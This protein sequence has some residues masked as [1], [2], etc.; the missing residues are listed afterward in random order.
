[1]IWLNG[2]QFLRRAIAIRGVPIQLQRLTGYAPNVIS[3]TA[4]IRGL[5]ETVTQNTTEDARTGIPSSAT[6]VVTQ[7][8]RK[9][10]LIEEDLTDA[11]FPLPVQ[12]GDKLF[13]PKTNET[14]TISSVD[15]YRSDVVGVIE[16]T[17]TGASS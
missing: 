1:M 3:F 16:M 7:F 9:V 15:P 14:L 4:S 6:G 13:L 5:V 12:I 2:A 17:A 10:S 11:Q 8:D